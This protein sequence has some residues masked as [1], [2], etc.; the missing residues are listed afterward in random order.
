LV[1][2]TQG[3]LDLAP[4]R[5]L[6]KEAGIF[7]AAWATVTDMPVDGRHNSKIDRPLLRDWLDRSKLRPQDLEV[8]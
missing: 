6:M 8:T 5:E 7:R 1:L 2:E 4:V 3:T